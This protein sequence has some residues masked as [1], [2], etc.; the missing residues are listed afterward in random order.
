M[1]GSRKKLKKREDEILDLVD[2]FY[3]VSQKELNKELARV[4]YTNRNRDMEK[5]T[6]RSCDGEKE[7]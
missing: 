3:E 1:T 7:A 2:D 5:G 4:R 6:R